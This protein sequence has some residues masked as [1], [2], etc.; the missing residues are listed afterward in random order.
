MSL[1]P[2]PSDYSGIPV[3]TTLTFTDGQTQC[4]VY[5][6]NDDT[7]DE[8]DESFFVDLTSTDVSITLLSGSASVIIEDDGMKH[9]Q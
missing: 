7:V 9:R 1:P 8:N 2:A 6:I 5:S 4:V 3:Q